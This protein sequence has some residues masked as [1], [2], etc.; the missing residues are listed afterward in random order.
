[1]TTFDPKLG[2]KLSE[3]IP[4]Q[5]PAEDTLIAAFMAAHSIPPAQLKVM[6]I[7]MPCVHRLMEKEERGP[8]KPIVVY[9]RWSGMPYL[10]GVFMPLAINVPTARDHMNVTDIKKAIVA[11]ND[12]LEDGLIP[13]RSNLVR[14]FRPVAAYFATGRT[15]MHMS[16][17]ARKHVLAPA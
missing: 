15:L 8:R 9:T 3:K 4:G 2:L 14:H 16:E 6:S 13:V 17:E 10:M 11:R 7:A 12:I 5:A 1:M